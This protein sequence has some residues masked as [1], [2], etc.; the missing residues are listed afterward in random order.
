MKI[1]IIDNET[2]IRAILKEMILL[3]SEGMHII[4]E[5][6]GVASG[7][8]KINTFHPDI[9]M[10]DVEMNDGTGFDLLKQVINPRFQLIFTTAHNKYAVQAFKFSAMDYLLKPIDPVELANSLEKAAGKIFNNNLQR[11]LS[12]MMEQLGEKK[13]PEP[14]LVLKD[15]D[16]TYFVRMSDILYCEAEGAYTKFYLTEGDPIFVSRNLRTYEEILGPAG[17]I[18]THHSCLVNPDKIKIY[19]RKTDNGTVV[20]EGGHILPVAQRKKE[21]VLQ[22]LERR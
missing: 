2:E 20:L 15:I 9:V 8:A 19:D 7:L 3:W 12:V 17:F 5:A 22:F 18:R 10:L 13:P 14:Q 16:K 4:A 6:D 1:L 11:Q 21:F